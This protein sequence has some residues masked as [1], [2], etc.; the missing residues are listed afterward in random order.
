MDWFSSHDSV[1]LLAALTGLG[2]ALSVERLRPFRSVQA[3]G[4][5]RE[6]RHLALWGLGAGV[7]LLVPFVMAIGSAEAARRAQ[8]GLLNQLS[9]PEPVT[10]LLTLL[11][12]DAWT[13]WLHR[14]YHRVPALWR[15]HRVHH[16]DEAL[17]A[18]TS[19]RFHPGE[20]LLS[21]LLRI[22]VVVLL[23][24]SVPGILVFEIALLAASQ[25]QHADVR[26]P[27]VWARGIG[28]LLITP[29]LHRTHHSVRRSECDSNFGTISSAWDRVFGTLRQVQPE[30]VTV[31]L[32]DTTSTAQTLF[33]LL[34]MPFA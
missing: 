21:A 12:L 30:Q 8:L 27:D 2:L 13:Y 29:N 23:G 22:P 9:L 33:R 4:L 5:R 17:T 10:I 26:L 28:T 15:L 31:G 19:V 18:T 14:L 11:V 34:R 3:R 32:P 6:L 16:S 20:V 1:R 24:A 7:L 25:L